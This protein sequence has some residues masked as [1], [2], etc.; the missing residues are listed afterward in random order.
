MKK[1]SI[2]SWLIAIIG[3]IILVSIFYSSRHSPPMSQPDFKANVNSEEL[4]GMETGGAPWPAEITNLKER[5]T[6]IGLPV[7]SAEGTNFHIHQH[8]DILVSK[9]KIEVPAGIGIS[10]DEQFI[11]PVHTH[12]GTGIIHIESDS[13]ADFTLG[14]FFDVWGL[15]FS[16][17]CIGSYC[18]GDDREV[19]VFINGKETSGDPRAVVLEPHQEIAVVYGSAK[20]LPPI[21]QSYAFPPDY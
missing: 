19:A 16:K 1:E 8:I 20:D 9:N 14:Q 10:E 4:P 15:R 2:I 12:D 17:D 3:I 11:S 7:L 5:L 13:K 18:S 6:I 21:P